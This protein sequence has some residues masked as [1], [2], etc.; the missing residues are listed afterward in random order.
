MVS[1]ANKP[2]TQASA[3][4]QPYNLGGIELPN[5]MIMAPLTRARAGSSR[6]P[7]E[8]MAEYYTQRASAGLIITEATHISEQGAGWNQ[9]PGIH[10]EEQVKGWRM[11]TDAVHKV[12][13]RIFLQ[14]WHTGRASHPDFQPN[15]AIPVSASAIRINGEAHT[16]FGKKPYVT[17]RPLELDEIPLVVQDYANATK[18]AQDAGFDGV[19]I[20]AANGYLIDQ[21]LRDGSNKRTDAYGGSIQK[22]ARFLLEVTEAV[23]KAWSPERVGVRLSPTNP[24]NDMH[25]SDPAVT[26]TYAATEL[27]QFKLV[28]LHSL[29][30][31]PGHPL[32]AE[33]ERVSPHMRR[34]F[35]GT[36]ML[37]GGYDAV[38]GANAITEGEADLIAYGVPFI[39]NPDLPKRYLHGT[40]LNTPDQSTFYTHDAKGYTDYPFIS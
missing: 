27:N 25:D 36:F 8:L 16:Q 30:A 38:T 37:N 15:G 4:F 35:Q 28:Y 40:E 2:S 12:G 1:T 3:L 31:L 19:E 34:A 33:I 10:T 23:V 21:F 5:R 17:P 6:I 9:T 14:L 24:F 20:H 18:R 7:N 26:F 13:G 22:R 39:A 29:E 32:A 11:I